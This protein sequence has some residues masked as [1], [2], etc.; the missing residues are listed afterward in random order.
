MTL[1]TLT[2]RFASA[3]SV[4]LFL[5]IPSASI[6]AELPGL[7]PLKDRLSSEVQ[8]ILDQYCLTCHSTEK[9]KGDF[10]LEQ[11]AQDDQLLK[12]GREWQM[13]V[14]QMHLGEMPPKDKPQPSAEE[15]Q[16]LL[17]WVGAHLELTA[18][19]NAGDPGPVVLRR[20]NNAEYTFTLRDL[21]GV[22]TLMPAREFPSDSAAGEGFMNTGNSL[23]MS[24]SLFTKYLDAAKEVANHAVLLSDGFRFSEKTTRRDLTEEVLAQ[25]RGLYRSYTDNGRAER[26][27]LQGIVFDTNEGGRLPFEKYLHAT[28]VDRK[29]LAA[30]GEA[31]KMVAAAHE[32]NPK[33]L[34]LLWKAMSD[35]ESSHLLQEIRKEWLSAKAGDEN[36]EKKIAQWQKALWRFSS[37]GHI[38]KAGGPKAWMEPVNPL[39][40]SQSFKV[41]LVPPPEGGDAVLYLTIND[42]GDG[43]D[44]DVVVWNRPR[45]VVPGQP[46]LLLKDVQEF[47]AEVSDRKERLFAATVKCLAAAAEASSS[48]NEQTIAELA[49]KHEVDVEFLRVWFDYLGIGAENEI[50][51]DYFTDKLEKTSGYEF[52]QGWGKTETPNIIANASDNHVRVPGNLKG[53]GVAVHPSPT[54]KAAVGWR[55]FE[56]DTVQVEAAITHAHPECGNGIEWSLELRRGK[57]RQKLASGIAQGGNLVSGKPTD[58]LATQKGDLISLLISPRDGNHSCDLTEVQLIIRSEK[59]SKKDWNLSRD[60]SGSILAGN[61]HADVSG[62]AGVWNFYTE[63]VS[64]SMGL[65]IPTGSLLT[66]WQTTTD[67]GEK[68]KLAEAIQKLLQGEAATPADRK[69]PDGQLYAQLTSLRGPLLG[70]LP[71][72]E[73]KKNQSKINSVA[74]WG[75]KPELFGKNIDGSPVEDGSLVMQSPSML[76]IRLPLELVAGAEFVTEAL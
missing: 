37:V 67:A 54:L 74:Q 14:D 61:P 2:R 65:V 21:T 70:S 53:K 52:V 36:L 45:L 46:D 31:F 11:M 62:Q 68:I 63:P 30:G 58:S 38:G 10:D 41:K 27:N 56:V 17:D 16:K 32:L 39:T 73:R 12:H 69:S 72:S 60:V 19:A 75:L 6:S 22:E 4:G 9:Q 40:P 8:P 55:S 44:G 15:R 28:I 26:V 71:Q 64:G 47:M 24:P 7:A 20:L 5:S 50:K 3:F 1:F 76:E 48:M 51:L 13:V 34:E 23:V 18:K 35:S 59:D 33:Y 42:G 57:L 49:S 43:S 29:K 25:I 66:R